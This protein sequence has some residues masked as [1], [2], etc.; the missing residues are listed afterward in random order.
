MKEKLKEVLSN[1]EK[2][3]ILKRHCAKIVLSMIPAGGVISEIMDCLY[4]QKSVDENA[5]AKACLDAALKE[6]FIRMEEVEMALPGSSKYA[7]FKFN[8]ALEENEMGDFADVMESF[9]LDFNTPPFSRDTTSLII[10]LPCVI[11]QV[12]RNRLC[13][14]LNGLLKEYNKLFD[15]LPDFYI[16]EVTNADE[17]DLLRIGEYCQ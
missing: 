17:D 13:V 7:V 3:E 9:D 10:P 6:F 1:E 11:T 4:E 15:A 2:H 5:E 8:R 12:R 16:T 14:E